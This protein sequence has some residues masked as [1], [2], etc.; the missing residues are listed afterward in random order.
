MSI[1]ALSYVWEHSQHKGNELLIMLA[2]A[3]FADDDG[4]HAY[5][6]IERLAKKTRMTPIRCQK[7]LTKLEVSE[8]LTGWRKAG[9]KGTH[10]HSINLFP[11]EHSSKSRGEQCSGVNSVQGE[12]R[13]RGGV[14][15]GSP[16]P[17]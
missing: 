13:G 3:D 5:P 6:S 16:N 8:E 17:S 1:F 11:R 15:G 4:T 7:C 10:L 14:N 12:Q 2:I 9:P